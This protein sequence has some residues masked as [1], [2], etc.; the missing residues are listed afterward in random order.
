MAINPSQG[1]NKK[2]NHQLSDKPGR[3]FRTIV[4][5][6]QVV[7]SL[8]FA[9]SVLMPEQQWRLKQTIWPQRNVLSANG[10][11]GYLK[12]GEYNIEHKEDNVFTAVRYRLSPVARQVM[13]RHLDDLERQRVIRK[14][15]SDYSS[16]CM[17]VRKPGYEGLP[18]TQA[19][20]SFGF[21]LTP[22]FSRSL[23]TQKMTIFQTKPN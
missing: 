14:Y 15:M 20:Q 8:E 21:G 7:D 16:P 23:S 5:Y 2:T 22:F 11:I 6:Q 18:I 4:K 19:K 1:L 17:L 3:P 10:D 12:N 13:K 9:G